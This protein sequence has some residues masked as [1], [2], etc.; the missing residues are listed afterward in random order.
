MIVVMRRV[1][2][3]LIGDTSYLVIS[4]SITGKFVWDDKHPVPKRTNTFTT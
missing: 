1:G 4:L 2:S 3:S